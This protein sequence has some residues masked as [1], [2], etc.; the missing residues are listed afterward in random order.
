MVEAPGRHGL[1]APLRSAIYAWFDRWLVGRMNAAPATEFPVKPSPD[2]DLLVCD[3]GQVNLSMKSRP[4][5]PMV[6]EEFE[7]RPRP[8]RVSL[9]D[10]LHRDSERADPFVTQI[11]PVRKPGQTAVVCVNGNESRDWREETEWIRTFERK[12]HAVAVVDPRGVGPTR[13]PIFAKARATPIRSAGRRRTSLTTP[14]SWAGRWWACGWRTCAPRSHE[15][16]SSPGRAG[17]SSAV[18]ETRRSWRAWRRPSIR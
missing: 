6:W 14:S 7:R 18:V 12:G 11:V 5:L 1:S 2:A 15:S 3:D 8:P 16:A 9:A 10:L 4:F 13:P 17:S